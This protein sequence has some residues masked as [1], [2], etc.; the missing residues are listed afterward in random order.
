MNVEKYALLSQ[1]LNRSRLTR[2]QF[3]T[4]AGAAGMALGVPPLLSGCGGSS[5]SGKTMDERTLFFNLSHLAAVTD[6]HVL[7]IAGKRFPLT[8][9]ADAPHVLARASQSN[10]F[11]NDANVAK[12]ITHHVESVSL[13]S[14]AV[15]LAYL[16]SMEDPEK[17]TWQMNMIHLVLPQQAHQ[18]AYAAIRAGTA[19][20][21][22]HSAKRLRYG[23]PAATSAR[24]LMEE[25]MLID[26]SDHAQTLIGMH[27]ELASLDPDTAAHVHGSYIASS[28]A[29]R[30]LAD[31]LATL[32][33]ATVQQT[34][35][36]SNA[37]G[38]A[39][40][41][42]MMN[43]R[44][45]PPVPY[46]K[47]DGKLNLYRAD[48]NSQVDLG[49]AYALRSIKPLVA[50]DPALGMDVTSVTKG[51]PLRPNQIKGKLWSW[52]Q[53]EAYR[54]RSP[55]KAGAAA[56]TVTFNS[57]T[58]DTGLAVGMPT[59]TNEGATV[60]VTLDNVNNWFLRWLGVWLQFRQAGSND[61]IPI[62]SLPAD[63]LEG[64]TGPSRMD[65][66]FA[67]FVGMMPPVSV[68]AGIPID[69]GSF[70]PTIKI[71]PG[72]ASTE[73][74]YGGLGLSGMK[75]GLVSDADMAALVKP[76]VAMT[77]LVNYVLVELFMALGAT[78]M[79]ETISAIV[80]LVAEGLAIVIVDLIAEVD[81]NKASA[82]EV[83]QAIVTELALMI[84]TKGVNELIDK[85]IE[86]V[87]PTAL[88]QEILDAM[89]VVG[90]IARAVADGL[91]ML[92]IA[93]TTVEIAV[94][95]PVYD[96]SLVLTRNVTLTLLPDSTAKAFPEKESNQIF[97][98]KLS[99][100]FDKG[101]SHVLTAVDLP[102]IGKDT[103]SVPIAL[104]GL[105]LGGNVK[106]T[107]TLYVRD[108]SV[109]AGAN[110]WCVAQASTGLLSNDASL[111]P[112]LTLTNNRIPINANTTYLHR[113]RTV[114]ADDG[115]H[116]WQ[117]D[118]NSPPYLPPPGDQ[119]PGLGAL[120]NITLRE[121]T[122]RNAGYV[123]YSWQAF[124]SGVP[125]CGADQGQY[126]YL[127]NVNTDPAN[128]QQGYASSPCGLQSGAQLS[129]SLLS[130]DNLNLYLDPA[131]LYL[132]PIQ[133]GSSPSFAGTG[134][135][136]G[137]LNVESSALLLH[138]AGHAVSIN[139]EH[140]VLE[141]LR[142][143]GKALDEATAA[144]TYRARVHAGRGSRPGL[145]NK[146][147]AAVVSSD[148][149]ILVLEA[150]DTNNRIQAFDLAGNPVSYFKGQ[151]TPWFFYLK[152]TRNAIYL[153]IAIEFGG[154]IY[155]LSRDD[156]GV[157]RLDIYASGQQD[158]DPICTTFNFNASAIAVDYSRTLYA[159]NYQ[160]LTLPGGALP[161]LTEP[162]ISRWSP[163]A[164]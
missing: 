1:L 159:L 110:D 50:D 61:L 161:A 109:P 144:R 80:E 150:S 106:V 63:T 45:Q 77:V 136:F 13:P 164:P 145:M 43:K 48:W 118:G 37:D 113:S 121:M 147:V 98:Y 18:R 86:K 82:G 76:G 102:P 89:P 107:I 49:V 112:A 8:P 36:R 149:V 88:T 92:E 120:R 73:V 99:Y 65:R 17:G 40:L 53:G 14:D 70:A 119:Q 5:G 28:P 132:R 154:Y 84:V 96:F 85:F 57:M 91:D 30:I 24:E 67:M 111:A 46:K 90:V 146:P 27:A 11:L 133:L 55:F 15:M 156:A 12:Q 69:P 35:G 127:A 140:H 137:Q 4:R 105:P 21:F 97:Y 103:Q 123:G 125:G 62:A 52:H 20:G 75:S 128:A 16:T 104:D 160:A 87:L 151:T 25:S 139:Q 157:H 74:L 10:A 152:S 129:Y 29:T 142:L 81:F 31:Q 66:P 60:K 134:L 94:S 117:N 68:L 83:V 124:S 78:P 93:E 23:L 116:R 71:P 47:S 122:V 153:D 148:G 3:L 130:D 138:P 108:A 59:V 38:W 95:P 135:A 19:G 64:R 115:S 58:T 155:V 39:T 72:A 22:P 131:Q 100:Q 54:E 101:P 162:S 6:T 2:R 143:P 9:I 158:T 41:V 51:Q 141:T 34:P 32:G 114:L 7:N 44:V 42:P 126:D 26:V 56:P 79:P 33:P 163:P